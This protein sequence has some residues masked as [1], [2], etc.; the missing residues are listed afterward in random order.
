[1]IDRIRS[2]N[3]VFV[4]GS[5]ALIGV[6][7]LGAAAV[8]QTTEDFEL[9]RRIN[10]PFTGEFDISSDEDV[11]YFS[12]QIAASRHGVMVTIDVDADSLGSDLDSY[13][14]VYDEEGEEIAYA[15]DTDGMDPAL[16]GPLTEGLYY[17]EVQG[18]SGSKGSYTLKV[19]ASPIEPELIALPYAGTFDFSAENESDIFAFEPPD[20]PYGVI[21]VIDI[22]ADSTGSDLD[23][24]VYVCD[25]KWEVIE[26]NDDTDG[27]DPYLK[28]RLAHG[29]Y[30]IV[31]EAYS[32][33]SGPYTLKVDVDA[34]LIEPYRIDLPHSGQS[35]IETAY[36]SQLYVV[37]LRKD[38][39][40]V[41]DI[42]TEA[43]AS[44]LD[45]YLY[46]YDEDWTEVASNDDTDGSDSYIEMVVEAGVYFIEVKGY[47]DSTG[48]YIL[49]VETAEL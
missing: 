29:T 3:W 36:E 13:M 9:A 33:S 31:V 42:D 35:E 15:D 49:T 46:L 44:D 6:L 11:H 4:A 23:S 45:S 32:D 38:A 39:T 12:F 30:Y 26:Y 16:S 20:S 17:I 22:D 8:G 47:N 41:I 7:A 24:I 14:S 19:D 34:Q 27:A 37:E 43:V 48:G 28:A 10:L 21:V 18:Y 1:M 2:T 25:A 40:I 5:L